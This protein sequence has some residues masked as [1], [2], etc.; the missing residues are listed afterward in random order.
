M[1]DQ[2]IER[3]LRGLRPQDGGKPI[4][5]ECPD[6]ETLAAL[7]D[8]TLTPAV[9][10]E[11]E[12]HVA[13]CHRCQM[14]TAAMARSEPVTGAPGETANEVSTWRRRAINWLVPAAAAATA[15]ALWVIVPGQRTPLPEEAEQVRQAAATETAPGTP[16]EAPSNRP[17]RDEPEARLREF[18][19]ESTDAR[20]DSAQR[21]PAT[22]GALERASPAEPP[23]AVAEPL[24][25]AEESLAITAQTPASSLPPSREALAD[26]GQASGAAARNDADRSE[27]APPVQEQVRIDDTSQLRTARA[28]AAVA[29][30]RVA[31]AFEIA[32]SN[33]QIRWR[34]ITSSVVQRSVDAG[35]TWITQQTVAA[36]ELIGGSA[37]SPD[38]CWLVGR[39][40]IVLRTADGGRQWQR[41]TIP[42]TVDLTTVTA[43]TALDAVVTAA[44]GRR[45]Q[46]TD[47]GRTWTRIP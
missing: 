4:D 44:D 41:T 3:L 33:P 30:A 2:A 29:G 19:P 21:V 8:D 39:G 28:P 47:G 45:F 24:L 38:V 1:S 22:A 16:S 13:D 23:P 42:A 15:V 32:S 37:P 40:G 27:S 9:R 46:T 26:R 7:A 34:V 11:L 31:V 25:K 6:A 10:R 14:L 36:T 18:A 43:S 5:G 17:L 12:T 35:A 20:A